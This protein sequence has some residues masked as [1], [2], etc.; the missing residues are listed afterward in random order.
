MN[1]TPYFAT[2]TKIGSNWT[3]S[4][5][6]KLTKEK[7]HWNFV[8]LARQIFLISQDTI[9]KTICLTF[10][11]LRNLKYDSYIINCVYQF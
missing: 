3:L 1:F 6:I 10:L 8:I 4:K 5:I 11:V 7:I 2:Y 9:H